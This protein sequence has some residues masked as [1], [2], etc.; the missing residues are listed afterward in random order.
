MRT[1]TDKYRYLFSDRSSRP[2]NDSV[3][4][5]APDGR[6]GF[7]KYFYT[8]FGLRKEFELECRKPEAAHSW[9]VSPYVYQG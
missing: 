3:H 6:K 2:H 7:Y 8:D 1:S 9:R 4:P 5:A